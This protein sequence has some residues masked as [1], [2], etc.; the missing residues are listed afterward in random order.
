MSR[1]L[2]EK[3]NLEFLKKQA[4]EL[5]RATPQT[6]LAEAQHALANDYGFS[7]SG[8]TQGARRKAVAYPGAGSDCGGPRY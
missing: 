6:K 5:Q 2:P 1:Q 8:K 4:K 7:T 3:P